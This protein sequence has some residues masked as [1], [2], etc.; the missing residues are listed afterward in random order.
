M[1]L[2]SENKRINKCQ[3]FSG[4]IIVTI[5]LLL[6]AQTLLVHGGNYY[7]ISYYLTLSKR[8]IGI[9]YANIQYI[10]LLGSN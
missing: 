10:N 1:K 8:P 7:L 4:N 3:F 5:A 6:L 9:V 2:T